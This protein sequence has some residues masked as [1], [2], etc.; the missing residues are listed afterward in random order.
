MSSGESVNVIGWQS[1]G[2]GLRESSGESVDVIGWLYEWGGRLA[3]PWRVRDG[4]ADDE[5]GL[6]GWFNVGTVQEIKS[7]KK[8]RTPFAGFSGRSPALASP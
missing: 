4:L 2:E 3:S 5:G 1:E 8:M 7:V 6:P